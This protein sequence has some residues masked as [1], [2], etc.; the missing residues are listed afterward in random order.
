MQTDIKEALMF[1]HFVT[2]IYTCTSGYTKVRSLAIVH[3]ICLRYYRHAYITI[4]PISLYKNRLPSQP[5]VI[6]S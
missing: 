6:T 5:F 4:T 2:M 1:I 3:K